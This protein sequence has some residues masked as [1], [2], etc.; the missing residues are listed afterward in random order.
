MGDHNIGHSK[1]KVNMYM[2]PIP[3]SKTEVFHCTD[4]QHVLTEV[5]TH[6]H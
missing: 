2:C 4:E 1:Q 3:V 6:V 5:A